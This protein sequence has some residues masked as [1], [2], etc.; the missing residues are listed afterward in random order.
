M[1][2]CAATDPEV[3]RCWGGARLD[4]GTAT[5]RIAVRHRVSLE[6]SERGEVSRE[7]VALVA[8][9]PR[10]ERRFDDDP[11]EPSTVRGPEK[12]NG[13]PCPYLKSAYTG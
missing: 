8:G 11:T 2:T 7:D 12:N 5:R 10:I 1:L 6:G 13:D 9:P 3:D 4:D